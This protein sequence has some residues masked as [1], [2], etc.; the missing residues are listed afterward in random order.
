M[1]SMV[2]LRRRMKSVRS[3]RQITKAMELISASKM[4]RASDATLASRYYSE[5]AQEVLGHLRNGTDVNKHPLYTTRPVKSRLHI[6][7]TSNRGLSGAYN[8]NVLQLFADQLKLDSQQNIRSSAILIGKQA[9]RFASRLHDLNIVG[10][11]DSLPEK[12]TISDLSSLMSTA[13]G[14]F[15]AEGKQSPDVD[16]VQIIFT[17]YVSHLVHTVAKEVMLPAGLDEEKQEP[18]KYVLFEPSAHDVLGV[19]TE[20]LLEVELLQAYLESQASEQSSRMLAMKTA[21]DNAKDLIDDLQL[22]TN[23]LRQATITQELA[24]ITGGAGALL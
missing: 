23:T 17:K 11:Y 1:S 3:T 13:I 16:E 24:E 14:L 7:I 8:K 4:R 15:T 6:V 21:S 10:L 12:P 20:R 19:V 18:T 5:V 2:S 22:A 9:G